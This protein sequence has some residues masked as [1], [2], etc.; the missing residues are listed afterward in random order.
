MTS[1]S[2]CRPAPSLSAKVRYD[3]RDRLGL[4]VPRRLDRRRTAGATN[5]STTTNP[6]GQ[7]FGNGI[8]GT[9]GGAWVTLTANL[10]AYAGNVLLGFRYWT[11]GAVVGAGLLGRRHRDHRA[12]VDGAETDAGWTSRRQAVQRHHGHRD[13]AFFNTYLAEFRQYPATTSA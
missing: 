12:A 4:R 13:A 11:D 8:T 6:N 10:S 7:N 3:A 2:R 5:L 1:R 9:T